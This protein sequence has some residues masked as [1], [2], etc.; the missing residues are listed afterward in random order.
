MLGLHT[1][2]QPQTAEMLLIVKTHSELL[3]NSASHTSVLKWLSAKHRLH[4]EMDV[5]TLF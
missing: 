3:K 2:S 5:L 4:Q 1:D